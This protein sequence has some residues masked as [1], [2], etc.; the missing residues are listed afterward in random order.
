M[1]RCP[2]WATRLRASLRESH[3]RFRIVAHQGDDGLQGE[4]SS[5]S[6]IELQGTGYVLLALLHSS[7]IEED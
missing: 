4:R 6:R 7:D 5:V 3:R 2:L 1:R